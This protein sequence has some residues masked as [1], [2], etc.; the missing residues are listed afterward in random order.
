MGVCSDK[1]QNSLQSARSSLSQVDLVWWPKEDAA[2]PVSKHISLDMI[3]KEGI[4][5]YT[6]DLSR[7]RNE[8]RDLLVDLGFVSEWGNGC[9]G[10]A[11]RDGRASLLR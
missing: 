8:D 6:F 3:S 7:D 10:K 2:A 5:V 4:Y 9:G 1:P 11:Y